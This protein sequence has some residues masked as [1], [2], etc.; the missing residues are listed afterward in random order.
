MKDKGGRTYIQPCTR[1][2]K[3]IV[4]GA[5]LNLSDGPADGEGFDWEDEEETN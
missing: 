2:I 4:K 5:I 1:T 3:I